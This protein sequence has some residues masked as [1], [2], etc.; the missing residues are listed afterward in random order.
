MQLIT[1][2][3]EWYLIARAQPETFFFFDIPQG[4][5]LGV[6][7]FVIYINDLP[8]GLNS[9]CKLFVDDT[10]IF[11]KVFDKNKSQRDLNN[12]LFIKSKRRFQ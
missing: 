9:I 4:S 1:E 10:F 5:V 2:N 6:L 12:D 11:F 7:L 8:N 3:K